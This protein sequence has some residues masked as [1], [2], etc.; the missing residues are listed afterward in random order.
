M[1]NR[2]FVYEES[3]FFVYFSMFHVHVEKKPFP[4]IT[5]YL[6]PLQYKLPDMNLIRDTVSQLK[7]GWWYII[8]FVPQQ[9]FLVKVNLLEHSKGRNAPLTCNTRM[10]ALKFIESFNSAKGLQS[11]KH[12]YHH[13]WD[14]MKKIKEVQLNK[15]ILIQECFQNA[16]YMTL[17]SRDT[18]FD[19]P[20]YVK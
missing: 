5:T 18:P 8:D 16:H 7:L 17:V 20:V 4:A 1:R 9:V 10:N 13:I 12:S 14:V 19:V 15:F 6:S 3:N 11:R 2:T